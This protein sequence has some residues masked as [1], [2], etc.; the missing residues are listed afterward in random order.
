M[1]APALRSLVILWDTDSTWQ[2]SNLYLVA[3]KMGDERT[4]EAYWQIEI[5][6]PAEGIAPQPGPAGLNLGDLDN[7]RPRSTPLVVGKV[8]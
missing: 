6:H 4:A 3:P 7:V 2:F 1:P 5:G 8:E